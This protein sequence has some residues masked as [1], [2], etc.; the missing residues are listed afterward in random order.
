M[1]MSHRSIEYPKLLIISHNLYDVTNNIGKTLVSLLDGWPKEKIAQI[2]FRNDTPSFQYCKEYYC[3]TD[4]D[5]LESTISLRRKKAGQ[6]VQKKHMKEATV[7]ENSMYKLGNQ[8]R[9]IVSL[10]RDY[11]WEFASWKTDALK[12]WLA[13]V[14]PDVILFVPNDYCLAYKVVLFVEKT[15]NKPIVPFYMDDAFYFGCTTDYIDQH[16]R[17]QIRELARK[18][19]GYSSKI[20]TIC[21][22]MSIEYEAEFRL[23][24][25]AYVNSVK[26][27][28]NLKLKR[29]YDKRRFIISYIGNLHSKRWKSILQIASCIDKLNR[30]GYSITLRVFSG[31][32]LEE[33]VMDAL[34]QKHCLELHG[35]VPPEEVLRYQ[36]ESDILLHVEAFDLKSKYSTRLS[37]S[38][39]IPEYLSTGVCIFAYGPKDIASIEYLMDHNVA[40]VCTSKYEL[41]ADLEELLRSYRLRNKLMD[42]GYRLARYK[43]DI[44]SVSKRF[45]NEIISEVPQ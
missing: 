23:P 25:R 29:A 7:T 19:H 5:T 44:R 1:R 39:K 33:K 35:S 41:K 3:I 22:K 18:V 24:C 8:R 43:H 38:T 20:L 11:M 10:L 26:V 14:R 17:K 9:P 31:T 12:T 13:K 4:K 27:P 34:L 16:R 15:I 30:E 40:Q 28:R 45:Q 21:D 42:R 2:Y 37:L 36:L 6:R 32:P